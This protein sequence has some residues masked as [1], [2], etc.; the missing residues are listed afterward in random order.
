M[1]ELTKFQRYLKE[2]ITEIRNVIK[3]LN[4]RNLTVERYM[5]QQTIEYN[6]Q[7]DKSSSEVIINTRA[8]D[9]YRKLIEEL[10]KDLEESITAL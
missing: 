2:R 10:E 7:M 8:M 3:D 9:K 5:E 4:Q 1:T 6:H